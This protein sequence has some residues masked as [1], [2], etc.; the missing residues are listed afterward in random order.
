MVQW[1]PFV[2]V[3]AVIVVVSMVTS[4]NSRPHSL[5]G[6]YILLAVPSNAI[7]NNCM[8]L[9]QRGGRHCTPRVP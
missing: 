1:R 6:T 9:V 4:K 8:S 3:S 2:S 7:A 5:D